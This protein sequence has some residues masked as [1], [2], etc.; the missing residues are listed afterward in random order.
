MTEEL[1]DKT[2]YKV[3]EFVVRVSGG[4][5]HISELVLGPGDSAEQLQ[6]DIRTVDE[7]RWFVMVSESPEESMDSLAMIDDQLE[8]Q[9]VARGVL[10]QD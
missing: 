2:P 5:F 6:A 1:N 3:P 4:T 9:V 8:F 7:D 10:K